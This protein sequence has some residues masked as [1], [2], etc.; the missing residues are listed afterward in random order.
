MLRT[1]AASPCRL[2]SCSVAVDTR[3]SWSRAFAARPVVLHCGRS[4]ARHL[5]RR[6]DGQHPRQPSD[7]RVEDPRLLT[8]GGTYVEDI[9]LADAAWVTYVRS[10]HAHARIVGIDTA[11]A[12]AAPGVVA[13]FT[14]AD[15]AALGLVP[16]PSPAFP[17]AMRRPFLADRHG[18]LRR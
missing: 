17:E 5:L 2:S 13:V 4:Q 6:P 7:A 11:D 1:D 3:F 14:G 18:P 8:V 15:L 12:A 10:P 9:E 16:H